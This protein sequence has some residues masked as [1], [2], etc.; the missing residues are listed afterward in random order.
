VHDQLDVIGLG[1][2]ADGR[3][4]FLVDQDELVG[5]LLAKRVTGFL[6]DILDLLLNL[7]GLLA[8]LLPVA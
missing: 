7:L 8:D 1:V 4:N 5:L 2:G 6:G 3:A